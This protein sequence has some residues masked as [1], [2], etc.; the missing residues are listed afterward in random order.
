MELNIIEK[1]LLLAHHPKKGGFSSS[2]KY[3]KLGFAG[4][5]FL[6][7]ALLD[8][9]SIKKRRIFLKNNNKPVKHIFLKNILEELDQANKP[10]VLKSRIL[11]LYRKRSSDIWMF[12]EEIA[13]KDL[14]H[15]EEKNFLG[16]IPY[17]KSFVID[18]EVQDSLIADCKAKLTSGQELSAQDRALIG[19]IDICKLY[20]NISSKRSE[21]RLL[22]QN[23]KSILKTMPAENSI[24]DAVN[25]TLK[26]INATMYLSIYYGPFS[27]ISRK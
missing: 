10:K 26:I 6:E 20:S 1:F 3:I 21:R 8:K 13:Y 7:L 23:A 2:L 9:L 14:V 19:L 25:Q 16:I 4:S 17:R 27:S 15:V 22:E 24:D 12:I 11:S 18:S 5:V